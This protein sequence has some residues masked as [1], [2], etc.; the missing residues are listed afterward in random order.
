[1][2]E[3]RQD[4]QDSDLLTCREAA[5]LVGV[6][7]DRVLAWAAKG[8]L[9][10]L[11]KR[12]RA[13][14]GRPEY[15]IPK[16]KVM[17]YAATAPTVVR[18]GGGK[19]VT[20]NAPVALPNDAML[21]RQEVLELTHWHPTNLGK[22]T[23]AGKL[24]AIDVLD[25]ETGKLTRLWYRNSLETYLA[26][27][28]NPRPKANPVHLPTAAELVDKLEANVRELKYALAREEKGRKKEL[29]ARLQQLLD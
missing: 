23:K 25:E 8:R 22:L 19:L 28:K 7:R 20:D 24:E 27:R 13:Q 5:V 2:D 16:D 18:H 6:S 1:M 21:T 10:P 29:A 12:P 3:Q 4:E 26:G 9:G 14:G 15:R 11:E 17:A